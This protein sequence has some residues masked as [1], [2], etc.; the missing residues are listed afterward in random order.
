MGSRKGGGCGSP[1]R[2]AAISTIFS[3]AK[4]RCTHDHGSGQRPDLQRRIV[5]ENIGRRPHI[6]R[7]LN[8]TITYDTPPEKI[9]RA[10][11]ILE[12]I[13]AVPDERDKRPVSQ[14]EEERSPHPNEAIHYRGFEPRVYFSELNADSLNLLAVY[15]FRPPD[16]WHFLEHATW[17]NMQVMERFNNEDI[18]FALPSQTVYLASNEK[19]PLSTGPV[20]PASSEGIRQ[21]RGTNLS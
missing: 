1:F 11:E 4:F 21:D 19:R 3:S 16:Y 13:L 17:V 2:K 10:I 6:R 15:W 14:G 20:P 18:D 12:E 5:I 7:D 8:V 9:R